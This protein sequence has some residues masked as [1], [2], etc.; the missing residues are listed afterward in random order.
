[1]LAVAYGMED[2]HEDIVH[3]CEDRAAEVAPEIQNG[4]GQHIRR[5]TH[6]TEDS[7]GKGDTHNGQRRTGTQTEG[8]I[9][10]NG[11]AHGGKVLRAEIF[12]DDDTGTHGQTVEEADHH[13]DQT[14]GGTDCRKRII[15]DE[16]A[17]TPGVKGIIKLL[18]NVAQKDRK[19]KQKH[20][21]P[22]GSLCQRVLLMKQWKHFLCS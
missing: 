22:D 14:A 2:A 7:R 20:G 10:V 1:M 4:L 3:H 8:D 21:L 6:P 15:T 18:K 16:V 5:S 13:K 19:R 9:R 11:F 17:Y 12:G